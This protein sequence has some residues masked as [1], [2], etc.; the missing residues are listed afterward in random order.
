MSGEI[1]AI[2]MPKWGLAMQEGTLLKWLVSEGDAIRP[3]QEICDIETS[4]ITNALESTVSGTL[5]RRVVEEGTLLPVGALMGVVTEGAVDGAAIDAFVARF[6]EAFAAAAKEQAAAGP[7][8][9]SVEVGGVA[10]N[11]V[12]MGEG[13]EPVVFLHGF[14]GDLNSWMFN[15]PEIAAARATYALDLPGHGASA[16]RVADGSVAGLAGVVAGFLDALAIERAHLVGHSLGGAIAL[17]LALERPARVASLTLVAGAGLGPEI[18]IDYIQGFI[19]AGGRRDIKPKLE[20]LF[21]DPSLVTRDMIDEVLKYK[22]LDGVDAALKAIAAA[23]FAGGRQATVLRDRLG[24][25]EV[26]VQVVAGAQDRIIPPAHAEGLPGNVAVHRLGNA[27]HMPHM[28]AA[29]D[30]N[31]L[32]AALPG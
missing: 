1:Q 9:R 12:A 3:G 14:G 29:G 22:R 32:L 18:N 6:E 7:S 23:A 25:V 13:G 11:Y 30:V 15:Q 28:E 20:M 4:K 16:K 21:A 5:V 10:I 27:G 19:A 31:R 26:P 8:N 24:E 2:V 17:A